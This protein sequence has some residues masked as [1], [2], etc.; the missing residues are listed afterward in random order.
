[1]MNNK[2]ASL[3][4]TEC[5]KQ[6]FDLICAGKRRVTL[7]IP[8]GAGKTV[9]SILIAEKICT[10]YQK[11]LIITDKKALADCCNSMIKEYEAKSIECI[12]V[13]ELLNEQ[14]NVDLL[15]LHC[16]NVGYRLKVNDYI[17]K[18]NSTI[19]V[20]MNDTPFN[21]NTNTQDKFIS[22]TVNNKQGLSLDVQIQNRRNTDKPSPVISEYY[23]KIIA[24]YMK[25]GN[26]KP[27]VYATERIVDVRDIFLADKNEKLEITSKIKEDK[28]QT[29]NEIH[30]LSEIIAVSKN[31]ELLKIIEK[32]KRRLEFCEKLLA[33]CG[34][35]KETLDKEFDKI[36]SMRDELKDKFYNPDGSINESIMSQY[37]K[38]VTECVE[39]CSKNVITD[40]N[41][42]IA[43]EELKNFLSENVWNNKLCDKTKS[44]LITSR[45]NYKAMSDME[46]KS[47]LDYS[48]VCLL[49]T[50]ALDVEIARRLYDEYCIY[51]ERRFPRPR[52]LNRWPNS[53]LNNEHTDIIEPKDFTLGTVMYVVGIDNEGHVKNQ[54]VYNRF[55]EFAKDEL[56]NRGLSDNE[57]ENRIVNMVKCVEKI[58]NDYRNPSAHRNEL[59]DVTAEECMDYVLKTYK[60]MKEILEDMR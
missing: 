11:A 14:R 33:N 47:V 56:Y 26:I 18:N 48:G 5:A 7:L 9:I 19:V 29:V 52:N 59:N 39:E 57:R 24:Y 45:I 42:E 55:K 43:A 31:E 54:Y 23:K 8:A 38:D 30:Q 1:M 46:N 17:S 13:D 6:V 16:L 20:S 10:T 27:V 36:E 12:T 49:V 51:L 21:S 3:Y 58:R 37:E 28:E 15:I 32:L 25:M 50:K 4:Q 2:E 60:K 53:L 44:F 41:R 35:P 34:I 22:Y 40:E